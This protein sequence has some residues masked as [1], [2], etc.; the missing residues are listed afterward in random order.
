MIQGATLPLW[1]MEVNID[2]ARQ[3]MK[4]AVSGADGLESMLGDVG[5]GLFN[6]QIKELK[7]GE[8][9]ENPPPG[10][11]EAV[12]IASVRPCGLL[13]F[14]FVELFMPGVVLTQ[15]RLTMDLSLD[16]MRRGGCRSSNS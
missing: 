14:Q 15:D 6:E 4:E 16:L 8:L 10:S 11:D 12:A 5:L 7:L 2:K 9:L 13:V 1:G 3:D